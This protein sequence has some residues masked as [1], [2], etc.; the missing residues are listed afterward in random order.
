MTVVRVRP[1]PADLSGPRAPLWWGVAMLLIIE[2]VAYATL[3]TAYLYLRFHSP[4]WPPE[5][6]PRPAALRGVAGTALLLGSAAAAWWATTAAAR[7]DG[8]GVR[9]GFL[10]AS[11]LAAASLATVAWERAAA[12]FRWD[13]NAYA[14]VIWTVD[15]V[16]GLH[17]VA[18][19]AAG[20][21]VAV[22]AGRLGVAPERRVGVEAVAL[23]WYGVAAAW[24]PVFA[25]VYLVAW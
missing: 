11:A 6:M 5:G 17:L 15:V 9:T 8:A 7:A 23:F 22:L 12:G 4:E 25:V 16:H 2:A 10:L 14:S 18:L 1:L 19:V 3:F 24:L 13:F 20:C 21:S